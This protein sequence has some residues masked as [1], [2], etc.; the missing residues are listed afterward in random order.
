VKGKACGPMD[1]KRGGMP[2]SPM[3][4]P[5]KKTAKGGKKR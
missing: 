3:P 2:L 1:K 5:K 4:M